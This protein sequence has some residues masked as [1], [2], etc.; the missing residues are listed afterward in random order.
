MIKYFRL[1][2]FIIIVFTSCNPERKT[3]TTSNKHKI[4]EAIIVD[5]HYTLK[6]AISGSKAPKSV[7][8]QL[9]LIDVQYYSTDGKIHRGQVLT[10]KKISSEIKAIFS[11]IL[12]NKFPV[13]RVIPI[14]KY[15]WDDNASMQANNAYSFCYRN[16]SYSKHAQGLAIDINPFFNPQRWKKNQKN[17]IDRPIGAKYDAK[18]PGTFYSNHPVVQQFK[19]LGFRWGHT[20]TA[21]YDDHHFELK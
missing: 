15:N 7:L 12:Q 3:N 10:N 6:E 13:A 4:S 9:E 18:V 16:V 14:V 11:F 5:C 8:N 17:R 19:K 2:I 20:F 21:K 1:S